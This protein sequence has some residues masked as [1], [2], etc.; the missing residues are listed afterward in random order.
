MKAEYLE[1]VLFE[2]SVQVRGGESNGSPHVVHHSTGISWDSN[3]IVGNV[4]NC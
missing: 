1:A 4:G 2:Y 3:G